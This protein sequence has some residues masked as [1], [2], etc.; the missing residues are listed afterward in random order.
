MKV[1][2]AVALGVAATIMSDVAVTARRHGHVH[3]TERH[4]NLLRRSGAGLQDNNSQPSIRRRGQKC[5]FPSGEGLVAVTPGAANGGWAMSPDQECTAGTYCPYACPP[6]QVMAQWKPGSTFTYPSSMD[7][8]IYCNQDGKIEKPFKDQPYCID[9]TGTV[10]AVNKAGSP[11]SF[12]Q[13]V[14]PGNEAMLIPTLVT[15]SSVIAV[16]DPSYWSGTSAHFYIN[17][18]GVG[19]EGCIWGTDSEAIGNWTPY[20]AGA[21]TDSNGRTFLK[22]GWNNEWLHAGLRSSLPQYGLSIECDNCLGMP[23]SISPEDNGVNGIS[24][25]SSGVEAETGTFC[26][27]TVPKGGSAKIVVTSSSGSSSSSESESSVS[28]GG[29]AS[30][31]RKSLENL[32]TAINQKVPL[33]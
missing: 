31:S 10:S 14:L 26:V 16:P 11:L 4:E 29:S 17:P 9:G 21:N 1:R 32:S 12:C 7:G 28:Q 13:T 25:P 33:K 22:I 24:A 5:S 20:V 2:G 19:T 23:C 3:P 8:G 18:P 15:G 6:G 30:K 27:V